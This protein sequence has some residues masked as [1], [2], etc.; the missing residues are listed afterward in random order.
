[1]QKEKSAK[2]QGWSSN[3]IVK[4]KKHRFNWYMA[5]AWAIFACAVSLA[6]IS[7]GIKNN[8]LMQ[9]VA[10]IGAIYGFS[11]FAVMYMTNKR[12]RSR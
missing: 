4:K 3:R 8:E 11:G 7:F 1:M 12:N 9:A 6:V 10:R 5:I 2:L